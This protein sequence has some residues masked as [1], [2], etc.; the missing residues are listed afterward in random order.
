MWEWLKLWNVNEKDRLWS[1]QTWTNHK[2]SVCRCMLL[3]TGYAPRTRP[4]VH[5]R[6]MAWPAQE[7]RLNK[8]DCWSEAQYE[9]TNSKP[10]VSRNIVQLLDLEVYRRNVC[11][12]RNFYLCR[13]TTGKCTPEDYHISYLCYSDCVSSLQDVRRRAISRFPDVVLCQLLKYVSYVI[14]SCIMLGETSI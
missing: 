9:V 7:I 6:V 10:A 3:A 13:V 4:V 1:G 8:T 12:S 14:L 2:F 11:T 5:A